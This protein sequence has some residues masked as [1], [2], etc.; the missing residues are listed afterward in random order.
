MRYIAVEKKKSVTKNYIYNLVYQILV[1]VLPLITTPY[2]S[3]VLGA[4]R[5]GV[6]S[7]TTSIATYFILFGSLGVAMYAQREIAYVQDDIRKRTKIFWEIFFFRCITMTI[8]IIVFY[9]TYASHGEYQL[10][11]KILII[12]LFANVLD[13]SWFFQGLEEFK[14]TVTRNLLVKVLSVICIFIFVKTQEDLWIYFVIFVLSILLGNMSLWVYLPKYVGKIKGEKLQIFSHLKPTIGLFIPQIAIDVYTLLDRTMLGYLT[15]DM[16][17]V[18]NYEQSQKIL[19]LSYTLITSL[20]TVMTPRIASVLASKD[21][22]KVEEYLTKS[23]NFVFFLGIPLTLGVMSVA[24]TLVPWFLGDEFSL[25]VYILMAGS[26]LI[27]AK[28]FTDVAGV[29]Y[30]IPSRNQ[31]IFT[32]S[33]VTGAILNV[34]LN[35]ILIPICGAIGAIIASVIAEVAIA[36]VQYY[37]VKKQINI[38]IFTKAYLKYII[39]GILMFVVVYVMG[40]FMQ[41]TIITTMLQICVGGIIYIGG[42]LIMKDQFL[43]ERL[44]KILKALKIKK[45]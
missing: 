33:V 34:I 35:F 42:L 37:Y 3:G 10:Y 8:S 18:G 32:K 1:I 36:I 30:L 38:H 12:Q 29:Q 2:I 44:D 28:G 6:Y 5:I 25:S 21:N 40:I 41:D 24:R 31:S 26:L 19:K 11:Y 17:Q 4:E 43:W 20:G 45:V 22:R 14:K 27:I 39:S 23:I 13:I 16:S 7:F 9:F 15:N